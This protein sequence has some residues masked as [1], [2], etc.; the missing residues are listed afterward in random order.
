MVFV[1]GLIS[2]LIA[3]CVVAVHISD[4]YDIVF[5]YIGLAGLVLMIGSVCYKIIQL[6]ILP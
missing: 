3:K 5:V 6:G 2:Y 4:E 1:I